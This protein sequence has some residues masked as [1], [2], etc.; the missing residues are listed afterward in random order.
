MAFFCLTLCT[1][2]IV[3]SLWNLFDCTEVLTAAVAAQSMIDSLLIMLTCSLGVQ[4][5][6]SGEAQ[7]RSAPSRASTPQASTKQ[8]DD[9]AT[10]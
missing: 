10:I 6:K 4:T 5:P 8:L 2:E 1:L 9:G 7:Q 3:F